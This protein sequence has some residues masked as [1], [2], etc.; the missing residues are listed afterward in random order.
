MWIAQV[1][2]QLEGRCP[3]RPWAAKKGDRNGI[4]GESLHISAR[5][6]RS[7]CARPDDDR[8]CPHP[9]VDRG[10]C[11]RNLRNFGEQHRIAGQRRRFLIDKRV[12]ATLANSL[13]IGSPGRR[14]ARAVTK[15]RDRALGSRETSDISSTKADGRSDAERPRSVEHRPELIMEMLE[16][17]G[18]LTEGAKRS[19]VE[20]LSAKL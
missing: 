17:F 5:D 10:C 9:R 14:S 11:L 8:V 12:G 7:I 6:G 19:I 16:S 2:Y 1:F 15:L 3:Q 4:S 18:L 20:R 13:P